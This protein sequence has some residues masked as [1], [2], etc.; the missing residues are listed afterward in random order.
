MIFKEVNNILVITS[1]LVS[2]K[3]EKNYTSL[4]SKVIYK[5]E[6]FVCGLTALISE[7]TGLILKY[8]S[9]LDS[10]FI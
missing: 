6:E 1:C 10:P 4:I 2:D 8:L 3:V 7:T 5:A 9:V